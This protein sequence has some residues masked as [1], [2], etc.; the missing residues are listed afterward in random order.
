MGPTLRQ[1]GPWQLVYYTKWSGC[2]TSTGFYHL[3]V[4]YPKVQDAQRVG[5][6]LDLV[7]KASGSIR[8]LDPVRYGIRFWI[9]GCGHYL[10]LCALE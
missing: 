1:A 5:V 3:L 6:N 9:P 4:Y 10:R 7:E 2:R 8:C